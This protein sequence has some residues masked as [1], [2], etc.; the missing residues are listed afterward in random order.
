MKK[1]IT[2]ILDGF[3]YREETHGNAI[4]SAVPN[5]FNELM[6]KYPHTTL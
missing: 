4:L 1:I 5:N 3:G 6:K 2:V